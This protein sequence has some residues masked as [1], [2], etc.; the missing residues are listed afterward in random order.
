MIV[1]IFVIGDYP[2]NPLPY[3]AQQTMPCVQWIASILQCASKLFGE[4]DPFIESDSG[5]EAPPV[6]LFNLANGSFCAAFCFSFSRSAA[7]FALLAS[8]D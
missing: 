8:I 7:K 1:L 2:I 3:H 5:T 6:A 4:L